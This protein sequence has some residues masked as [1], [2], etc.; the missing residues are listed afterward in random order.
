MEVLTRRFV[1]TTDPQQQD[2]LVLE[3]QKRAFDQ[4]PYVPIGSFQIR[5]AYRKDLV[6]MVE[7]T[8]PY[9]WNVRRA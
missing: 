7:G 9:F 8:A 5:K 3:I 6:G 1:E 2:A 4:V